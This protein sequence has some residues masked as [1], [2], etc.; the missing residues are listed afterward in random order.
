MRIPFEVDVN[1]INIGKM[2]GFLKEV[3]GQ[4]AIANRMFEMELLNIFITKEALNSESYQYGE[5]NPYGGK[6]IIEAVV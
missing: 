4:V 2:F 1:P 6:M 5:G 3:N